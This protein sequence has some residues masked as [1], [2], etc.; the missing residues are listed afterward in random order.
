MAA[1]LV[2]NQFAMQILAM[3]GVGAVLVVVGCL[4]LELLGDSLDRFCRL[5][6]AHKVVVLFIVTRLT[7]DQ[8]VSACKV[9][10]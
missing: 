8:V 2:D 9:F 5:S 7:I 1:L 6:L 4:L 10:G 3:L